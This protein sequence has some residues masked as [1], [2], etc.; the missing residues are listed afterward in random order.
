MQDDTK[1][2]TSKLVRTQT[3]YHRSTIG[4]NILSSTIIGDNLLE[5]KTE[6]AKSK[7]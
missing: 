5:V 7:N 1:F 4:K 6:K 3:E 2:N